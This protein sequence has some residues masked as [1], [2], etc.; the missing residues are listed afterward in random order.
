MGYNILWLYS[1]FVFIYIV[2][3]LILSIFFCDL[4]IIDYPFSTFTALMMFLEGGNL[5]LL[6][7]LMS[8]SGFAIMTIFFIMRIFNS[9]GNTG[10]SRVTKKILFL[11]YLLFLCNT[12]NAFLNKNS[13]TF[14]SIRNFKD[15]A[16]TVR[17]VVESAPSLSDLVKDMKKK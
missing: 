15:N 11:I 17:D 3:K 12:V 9:N 7:K 1:F 8:S 2:V 14:E 4:S 13:T 10:G 16:R 6:Y 5:M